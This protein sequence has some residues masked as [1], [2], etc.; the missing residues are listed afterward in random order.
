MQKSYAKTAELV[1]LQLVLGIEE[2]NV[3]LKMQK[4]CV[5]NNILTNN[6]EFHLNVVSPNLCS[7]L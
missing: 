1:P 7:A 4:C 3:L 2:V 5:Q 6:P